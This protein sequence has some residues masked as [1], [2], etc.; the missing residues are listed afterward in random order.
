ME[1]PHWSLGYLAANGYR[2]WAK[3]MRH[4]CGHSFTLDWDGLLKQL[5]PET[6]LVGNTHTIEELLVCPECGG[7]ELSVQLSPSKSSLSGHG[8]GRAS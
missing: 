6:P 5:P 1:H 7:L 3:C 8:D 2:L 4:G